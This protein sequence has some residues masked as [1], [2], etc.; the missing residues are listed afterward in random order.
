[1]LKK[2]KPLS[3]PAAHAAG[4]RRPSEVIPLDDDAALEEF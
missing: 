4:V 3:R 1:V 2:G